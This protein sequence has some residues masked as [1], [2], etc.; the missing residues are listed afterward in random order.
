L[1]FRHKGDR[2]GNYRREMRFGASECYRKG[3]SATETRISAPPKPP[4]TRTN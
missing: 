2:Y 1:S 4:N 3:K